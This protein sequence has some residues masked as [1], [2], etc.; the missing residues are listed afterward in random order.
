ME[1]PAYR[2]RGK[3]AVGHCRPCGPSQDGGVAYSRP[4][5][6][7]TLTAIVQFLKSCGTPS[8]A[9]RLRGT[10]GGWDPGGWTQQQRPLLLLWTASIRTSLMPITGL[11]EN[12]YFPCWRLPVVLCGWWFDLGPRAGT[13]P[14]AAPHLGA[15]GR[16]CSRRATARRYSR[17]PASL[18]V[19]A[20][21]TASTAL[22]TYLLSCF[23]CTFVLGT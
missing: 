16:L 3:P 20:R 5:Q 18:E 10:I 15:W 17:A 8:P 4:T 9:S 1:C 2:Q 21:L 12:V 6:H 13:F 19:S 11:Y 23:Y 14:A 22:K 7:P